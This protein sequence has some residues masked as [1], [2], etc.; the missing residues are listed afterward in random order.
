MLI[1]GLFFLNLLINRDKEFR[2]INFYIIFLGFPDQNWQ[3]FSEFSGFQALVSIL[4][5]FFV[6][7]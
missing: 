1:L 5:H 6:Y 3:E 7:F 4:S 2:F